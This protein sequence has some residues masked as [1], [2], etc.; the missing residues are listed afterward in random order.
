MMLI[1]SL[2]MEKGAFIGTISVSP[3]IIR[4]LFQLRGF[5]MEVARFMWEATCAGQWG[6]IKLSWPAGGIWERGQE[7]PVKWHGEKYF[8]IS[9]SVSL[10]L[11]LSLS[12]FWHCNFSY[13]R[14]KLS[15]CPII[16]D[17]LV[18]AVPWKARGWWGTHKV[19]GSWNGVEMAGGWETQGRSLE[20]GEKQ[21]SEHRSGF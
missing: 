19:T 8:S 2:I 5:G 7:H 15:Q 14:L 11:S 12:L 9:L 20:S 18:L 17:S 13:G 3:D 6:S 21:P 4:N 16:C 10:S 1:F